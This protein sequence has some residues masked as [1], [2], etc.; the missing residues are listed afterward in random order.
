MKK[1]GSTEKKIY[2]RKDRLLEVRNLSTHF[3][4]DDGT[5]KAVDNISFDLRK[6]ETLGV[7]GESGCGKS[8]TSLS[9]M[10]LVPDPP[11]KIVGG[12]I[13][14]YLDKNNSPV[15]IAALKRYSAEMRSIRGD[16]IAMIFQEPMSSLNPVLTVGNQIIEPIKLHQD[17]NNKQA[18]KQAVEM[19]N[20]VG[21]GSP[22]QRLSEYPHQLSGG[23]RQRVMIAMAL[24]CNP[25]LLI[26]DE[27]TTALD[28]T[29]EAQI[30]ELM[31]ELQDEFKMSILF[32]THD[33]EVIGE[34]CERVMVMYTGTVVEKAEIEDIFYN[35][36]HP[37][38]RGLL[39]SIPK[40]GEHR[41]LTPIEGSVPELKNLPD[42][43]NFE[44]RCPESMDI[45]VNQ[46][47]PT[48][49][50]SKNQ[51]AKCWLYRNNDRE[52]ELS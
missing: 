33:L 29:I 34:M 32:I 42:G 21:I 25:N 47:P 41:R 50:I 20:L 15:D 12:N 49:I 26:A 23:L 1:P 8:V 51:K 7:V 13:F 46:E 18:R 38:T 45:C 37:Y 27:P 31:Q 35:N 6:G 3:L 30:L 22:T 43:C 4:L 11:G 24:S 28:V 44:P 14:Y 19:L 36:K 52:E 39:K 5:V 2:T 9:I 48:F 17:K 16:E 40:I 10:N